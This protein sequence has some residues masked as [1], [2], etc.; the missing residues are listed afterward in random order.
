MTGVFNKRSVF[1]S[2]DGRIFIGIRPNA[3][4][5]VYNKKSLTLQL[6]SRSPTDANDDVGSLQFLGISIQILLRQI[7][8]GIFLMVAAS[9]ITLAIFIPTVTSSTLVNRTLGSY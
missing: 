7:N 4:S 9:R 1:S 8:F 3:N 5:I 2:L 6:T